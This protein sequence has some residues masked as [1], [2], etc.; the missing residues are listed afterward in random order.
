M[1]ASAVTLADYIRASSRALIFTGAGIST[2]SGIPDFRGPNG[3]WKRRQ[4]V[5]FHDFMRSETARIEHWDYKLEGYE[6]FREARPNAV[7]HAIVRLEKAG[8]LRAVVTQNIDGLHSLAGTS[9]EKLIELH[10]TNALIECQSCHRRSDPE[11]HFDSFR[12]T[13]KPPL[14]EC[15][16][17]LKPATIS[18]GQNLD[19]RELARAQEAALAADLVVALGSTL[20]V[21]PAAS[22]PLLATERGAPYVIINQ[23]PT[24]HDGADCVTL[25]IEGEVGESFPAAVDAAIA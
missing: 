16:G 24:D 14:C 2:G 10:G 4:P 15:G 1:A 9:A 13:R 22:F 6:A 3:V 12:R 11:P 25:R 7:H 5:Y 17:F 21:Y 8:K 19:A 20:S 23:G 18:F